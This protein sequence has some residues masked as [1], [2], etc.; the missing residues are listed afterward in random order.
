MKSFFLQNILVCCFTFV[1]AQCLLIAQ[2]DESTKIT[3]VVD[4]T[5]LQMELNKAASNGE[6]D[7]IQVGEG[8]F[9]LS[10]LD[11]DLYYY[12][13]PQPK[14]SKEE[15][16][17]IWIKGAGGGKTIFDAGHSSRKF[18][19]TSTQLKDDMGVSITVEGITFRNGGSAGDFAGL[20][21]GTKKG[22]IE[23]K[24]CEFLSTNGSRGS[25]LLASTGGK[26]ELGFTRIIGCRFDSLSTSV[27]LG[28]T[29]SSTLVEESKFTNFRDYPALDIGNNAG[30]SNISKCTFT[31]NHT[32]SEAPLNA[33][34]FSGGTV[35]INN[36][37]FENN[38]GSMSGAVRVAGREAAVNLNH[39]SFL[40][41]QNGRVSGGASISMDGSGRI[42][43]DGNLFKE[44]SNNAN[45]G[46]LTIITGG[47]KT[48]PGLNNKVKI[49]DSKGFIGV[50]NNIFSKNTT[51]AN[52]G[53]VYIETQEGKVEIINNTLVQNSTEYYPNCD[54]AA[55]LCLKTVMNDATAVIY[56]NIFWNNMCKT[57]P[58]IDL[59][60]DN[61]PDVSLTGLLSQDG[62]GASVLVSH[63]I[64]RKESITI[65]NTVK[66][67]NQLNVDPLL[68]ENFKLKSNSPAIDAGTELGEGILGS[69]DFNR[70][71]RPIDGD[72]DGNA[73]IDIGAIEYQK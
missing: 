27:K 67:E 6:P 24:D 45:G 63:N 21:I 50:Y 44:N 9:D 4:L 58:G 35:E 15:R 34:V 19:L 65:T 51:A 8:V 60:I 36:S 49:D 55:G 18:A 20:F 66:V 41:N 32:I 46:G 38:G 28:N 1:F 23:V 62:I 29:R 30:V 48:V 54:K 12:P 39:N 33:S 7:I 64:I 47:N 73:K 11:Q 14:V 70:N 69:K 31:N 59:L 5:M 72:G 37:T 2:N 25:T 40:G 16:Y 22:R 10:L 17:A 71:S 56:N 43:I 52:G 26:D 57:K 42:I 13:L 53:G 68:D 61:D 3:S